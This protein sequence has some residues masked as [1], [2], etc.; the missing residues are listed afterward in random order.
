MPFCL[1]WLQA[2]EHDETLLVDIV[3]REQ[4]IVVCL[5]DVGGIRRVFL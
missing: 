3:Y 4:D 1:I 5:G 2:G